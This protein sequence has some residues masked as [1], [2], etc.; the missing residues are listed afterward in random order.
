MEASAYPDAL[1]KVQARKPKDNYMVI[2]VSY[3]TK[4]VLPY[5][6]GLVFMTAFVNAEQLSEHY[7]SPHRITPLNRGSLTS[8]VMSAQE[9]E[10]YKI[11]ALLNISVSDVEAFEQGT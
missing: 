6:D 3:D 11:A 4:V 10:R 5:K 7:D 1:K 2:Q 8:T 9:Y